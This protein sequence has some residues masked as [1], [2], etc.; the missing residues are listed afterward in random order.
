M[1]PLKDDI[2]GQRF[3]WATLTL[4][5]AN[6]AVFLWQLF[7]SPSFRHSIELLGLVPA[8]FFVDEGILALG[9]PSL[10]LLTSMFTHGSIL[11]IGSNLLFFGIFGNNVEDAMGKRRFLLFY[12]LCGIGAAAAQIASAPLSTIPMVGASGAV[13]GVLGASFLLSPRARVLTLVPIL[14]LLRLMWVPAVFFLGIWM[15]MQ[16]LGGLSSSP[17]GGGVAF[18]AHVGGFVA[19]LVLVRPFAGRL[20]RI[21][22][23]GRYH[24]DPWGSNRWRF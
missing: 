20:L 18:W 4:I 7:G 2:P 6:V 11:H 19:G 9:A 16:V 12:L 23:G 13:S 8:S 15:A 5:G 22:P 24:Q 21:T 17:D 10:S 3:P 14:F 1:I